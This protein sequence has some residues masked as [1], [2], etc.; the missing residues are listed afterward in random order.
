VRSAV[1]VAVM[2]AAVRPVRGGVRDGSPMI[3]SGVLTGLD[4]P[5]F[6]DQ[7]LTRHEGVVTM[8]GKGGEFGIERLRRR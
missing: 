4:N 1:T 6:P 8:H 5:K 7:P 3:P 2:L